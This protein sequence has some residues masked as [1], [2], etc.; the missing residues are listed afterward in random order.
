MI[1]QQTPH[2]LLL[3][4]QPDHAALSGRLMN[5]WTADGL[6]TRASRRSV[7]LAT[8]SHDDGWRDVDARA[9]IDRSGRPRDFIRMADDVK[10]AI[11]PRAVAQL[12]GTDS[13][14]AALVAEHALTVH[15]RHRRDAAWRGFFARLESV[16]DELLVHHARRASEVAFIRDYRV[17][18]LGD[19]LSLIFCSGWVDP[20]TA[21]GYRLRLR[22][23]LLCVTPDPFDGA[24]VELRVTA[25]QLPDR[26]YH[27]DADLRAALEDAPTTVRA[28][29]AVGTAVE[30]PQP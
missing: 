28:G 21:H 23:D 15:A 18:F 12:S 1:V 11:W 9:T 17:V 25:R 22:G 16:R 4:T 6:T 19:L 8:R 5:A 10:H 7:L 27:S 30:S 13:Y 29:R 14:A 3:L 2:G 20:F 26:R 24:S